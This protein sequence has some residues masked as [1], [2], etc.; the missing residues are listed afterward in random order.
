MCSSDLTYFYSR[1]EDTIAFGSVSSADPYGRTFG[2]YIN[3]KGGLSRGVELSTRVSPISSLDVTAAYTYVNALERAPIYGDV[4]RTFVIPRNQFSATVTQ[5]IGKR[6]VLTLDT[7]DSGNY[8]APVFPDFVTAFQTRVYRFGG[9]R[10]VN[11][12]ASYRLPLG[13]ST[14]VRFHI[15]SENIAGQD[16][17]ETGYRTPGRT[18]LGGLQFEF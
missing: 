8:L 15:R 13:E 16:Y 4:L 14:A 17:Y 1:L 6:M 5:R 10:R 7:L 11:A 18:A 2:G 12:G 9:L 3:S